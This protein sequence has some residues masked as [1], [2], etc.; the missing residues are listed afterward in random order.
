MDRREGSERVK[1]RPRAQTRKTE[2]AVDRRQ[3]NGSVK[4]VSLAIAQRLVYYAIAVSTAV[5]SRS[6]GQD[7]TQNTN[8]LTY[9][10]PPPP[11]P[12]SLP[13][14]AYDHGNVASNPGY[15]ILG[16]GGWGG[17]LSMFCLKM[18]VN[19]RMFCTLVYC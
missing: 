6:Q 11:H 7:S 10:P 8:L 18:L 17:E 15:S 2:E 19:F 1:A 9:P 5:R 4:A 14:A 3:N 16:G 13:A 12:A